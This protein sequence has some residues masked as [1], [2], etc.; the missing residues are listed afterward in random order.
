[1]IYARTLNGGGRLHVNPE[2]RWHGVC[3]QRATLSAAGGCRTLKLVHP[4]SIP[5][6]TC[7]LYW[8][9]MGRKLSG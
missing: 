2:E 6:P 7:F 5:P 3:M 4:S 9:K 8:G 1:M